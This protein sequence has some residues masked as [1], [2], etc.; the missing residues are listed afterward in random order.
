MPILTPQL[1]RHMASLVYNVSNLFSMLLELYIRFMVGC[2]K[3][4]Y[5]VWRKHENMSPCTGSR[6]N[7]SYER[8]ASRAGSLFRTQ[9]PESQGNSATKYCAE[10]YRLWSSYS[11]Y[12]GLSCQHSTGKA[13]IA[14]AIILGIRLYIYVYIYIY[15]VCVL[16]LLLLLV[17]VVVVVH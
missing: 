2:V 17:V 16:L 9:D 8:I 11:Y 10:C 12:S 13:N 1:C 5:F 14:T 6:V 7:T 15:I 3:F 4:G